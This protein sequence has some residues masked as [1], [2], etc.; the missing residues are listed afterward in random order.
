MNPLLSIIGEHKSV[1]TYRQLAVSGSRLDFSS[2]D[3]LGLSVCPNIRARLVAEL[4]SGCPL[5]ATGSRLLSGNTIYHERVEAFLA[6]TFGFASALLFSSGYMANLGVLY[7]L[8]SLGAE[9]FSD[10]L[11]HASLVDGMKYS[12]LKRKIFRHNDVDHLEMLLNQSQ[13]PF[14]VIVT[15]SVFSMDGD[16]SPLYEILKL[17]KGYN[18]CLVIDES[19]ATGIFGLE[20]LG[21]Y[22]DFKSENRQIIC[23]HTGGKALGGQGAFVLSDSSVRE[24][25]INRARTFIFSTALSPLSCLQ[26]EFAVEEIL[27]QPESRETLLN[28]AKYFRDQ[29]PKEIDFGSSQS[30]IVPIILGSN[31]KVMIAAKNLQEIG[32]DVRAIRSPTVA[33]GSERLRITIKKFHKPADLRILREALV[34]EVCA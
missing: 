8:S 22:N 3:Y 4:T 21:R 6:R 16:L 19:H 30:P 28:A 25:L 24:L 17:S 7:T 23:V 32:F 9:F 20:G 27:K 31:E 5:G 14:K 10:E 15:E 34:R 13:A 12:N 2:N 29:L 33:K 11:N 18:A 26:I 1:G